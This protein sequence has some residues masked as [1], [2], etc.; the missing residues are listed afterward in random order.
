MI[1]GELTTEV[2][3]AD[4]TPMALDLVQF[5]ILYT[6]S[7]LPDPAPWNKAKASIARSICHYDQRSVSLCMLV[8]LRPSAPGTHS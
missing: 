3:E 4:N 5:L 7:T 8:A 1:G 6:L 2:L